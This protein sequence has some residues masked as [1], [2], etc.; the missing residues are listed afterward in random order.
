MI[1]S[2]R[3]NNLISFVYS[4]VF[5]F[6][7]VGQAIHISLS[8]FHNKVSRYLF[9]YITPEGHFLAS[10]LL[11]YIVVIL[12]LLEIRFSLRFTKS[13]LN[14]ECPEKEVLVKS[15]LVMY[16]MILFVFWLIVSAVLIKMVGGINNWLFTGRPIASGAT[17]FILFYGFVMYP[18]LIKIASRIK[19]SFFDFFLF[20]LSFIMMFSFSRIMAVFFIL[21]IVSYYIVADVNLQRRN[22][23]LIVIL[24]IFLTA[25]FMGYGTYR[26]VVS[27]NMNLDYFVKILLNNPQ[28]SLFSLDLN[29]R[30]GV[31]GMSGFSGA[32]SDYLNNP[33]FRAALGIPVLA[34]I[35]QFVPILFR[36]F[37]SQIKSYILDFY[38]HSGSIVSSGLEDFFVYFSFFGIILYPFIF[39]MFS[40]GIE[41]SIRKI[42]AT[43][44]S[45][46]NVRLL[47]LATLT[48]FGLQIIRGSMYF[49]VQYIVAMLIIMFSSILLFRVFNTIKIVNK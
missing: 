9:N 19:T 10:L 48:S 41:S 35:F 36:D 38:W 24:G 1:K 47:L 22:K 32:M 28:L 42:V 8:L 16:Y 7:V 27:K 20:F 29:Y 33:D 18:L 39:F 5:V 44:K 11:L 14:F 43:D 17:V 15:S 21:G 49:L 34:S 40:Y 46:I 23:W 25:L 26:N 3:K 6:L 13:N 12:T 4:A 37:F 45:I 30:I 31:E 2:F